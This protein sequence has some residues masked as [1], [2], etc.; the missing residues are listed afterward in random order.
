MFVK[1][2]PGQSYAPHWATSSSDGV[3]SVPFIPRGF[4]MVEEII[5]ENILAE[6]V[7]GVIIY[8]I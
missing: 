7:I 5:F 1:F 6:N 2:L 3:S 8:E 4:K